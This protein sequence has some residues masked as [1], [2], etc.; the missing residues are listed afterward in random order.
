M[1]IHTL[2]ME[3]LPGNLYYIWGGGR[4]GNGESLEMKDIPDYVVNEIRKIGGGGG[5]R[6]SLLALQTSWGFL[7][8][9]I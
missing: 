3:E 4:Q 9:V 6:R 2:L 7:L 8:T 5:D 1:I